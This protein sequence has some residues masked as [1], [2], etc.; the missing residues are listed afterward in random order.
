MKQA[1]AAIL[2][3][4]LL[5]TGCSSVNQPPNAILYETR[6]SVDSASG[7]EKTFTGQTSIG[8]EGNL[9]SVQVVWSAIPDSSGCLKISYVKVARLGGD[10]TMVISGVKHSSI[11]QC[12]MKFESPDTTRYQTAFINAHYETRR[13]IKT[14]SFDGS[15]ASILGNGE[16]SRN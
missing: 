6:I 2:A 15:I 8:P 9:V 14:Y 3:V 11:P 16:F 13:F 5:S 10:P 7:P 4:P 1:I 12:M